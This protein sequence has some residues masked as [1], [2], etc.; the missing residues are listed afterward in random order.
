MDVW[1]DIAENLNFD[2]MEALYRLALLSKDNN[3][4]DAMDNKNFLLRL[5]IDANLRMP[6]SQLTNYRNIASI[7][8][9][10]PEAQFLICMRRNPGSLKQVATKLAPHIKD[11]VELHLFSNNNDTPNSIITIPLDLYLTYHDDVEG[12]GKVRYRHLINIA[13]AIRDIRY[14]DEDIDHAYSVPWIIGGK[15]AKEHF[16]HHDVALLKINDNWIN[17]WD[18]LSFTRKEA[19]KEERIDVVHMCNDLLDYYGHLESPN[20]FSLENILHVNHEHSLEAAL[21]VIKKCLMLS[22]PIS[23]Y[24][25][26]VY[27]EV[28]NLIGHAL[29]DLRCWMEVA[30]YYLKTLSRDELAKISYNRQCADWVDVIIKFD[31]RLAHLRTQLP[32]MIFNKDY[33]TKNRLLAE[34]VKTPN[35]YITHK[36]R[37]IGYTG[38]TFSHRN[39][40]LEYA[41]MKGNYDYVESV[42]QNS[43]EYVVDAVIEEIDID[44]N[45]V[46]TFSTFTSITAA[47]VVSK[48]TEPKL[49]Q[50]DATN[51]YETYALLAVIFY[52]RSR[53]IDYSH[54]YSTM[55]DILNRT[56]NPNLLISDRVAIVGLIG[57]IPY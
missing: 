49:W 17:F 24:D 1:F 29:D 43:P 11:M 40:G 16:N 57:E 12:S 26:G 25:L 56:D 10:S 30:V 18:A 2:Q 33:R 9:H 35:E 36:H 8:R 47:L 5:A 28:Y 15:I 48:Y 14:Q 20:L 23:G 31:D 32:H 38:K 21:P 41:L 42:L 46:E 45:N 22:K 3:F 44:E 50:Y 53:G 27:L 37:V 51:E 34:V 6:I 4:L 19:A 39:N 7:I 54:M 52:R 55:L 13:T